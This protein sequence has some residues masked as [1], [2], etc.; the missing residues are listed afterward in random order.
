MWKVYLE[1]RATAIR[2]QL[3]EIVNSLACFTGAS[4]ALPFVNLPLDSNTV[5]AN[6]QL[7]KYQNEDFTALKA[8]IDGNACCA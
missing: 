6:E 8:T 1:N 2:R 3:C 4:I 7:P 5:L